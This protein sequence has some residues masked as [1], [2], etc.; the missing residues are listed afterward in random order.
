MASTGRAKAPV[1]PGTPEAD[2]TFLGS[3]L[4]GE[5][6]Q[7]AVGGLGMDKGNAAAT[8][9]GAGLLINQG[10][11][12]GTTGFQGSVEVG[13]P[14]AHVMDAGTPPGQEPADRRFGFHGLEQLDL[15]ATEVEMNDPGTVNGFGGTRC[16]TEHVAVEAQRRIDALDG[17][18]E[19]GNSGIH[20]GNI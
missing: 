12:L 11:A 2:P 19:M 15:G 7:D 20:D 17:D 1:D 13:H 4:L 5:L 16:H 3:R 8:G 10:V 18:A 6:D 14:V 9:A